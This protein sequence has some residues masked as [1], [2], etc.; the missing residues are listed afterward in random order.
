MKADSKSSGP[1]QLDHSCLSGLLGYQLARATIPTNRIFKAQIEEAFRLNK[2]EFTLLM[3]SAHNSHV[4]PKRLATA[5]NVP[6][7]N[8]TVLLDRLEARGYLRREK[9]E[10]D[11]RLQWVKMTPEGLACVAALQCTTS[12]MEADLLANLSVAERAMLFEL[13]RKVAVHRRM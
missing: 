11:R 8:L 10:V 13:L 2:L 7:P 9:S 5:L 3:L 1:G 4:T 6:G 12:Q